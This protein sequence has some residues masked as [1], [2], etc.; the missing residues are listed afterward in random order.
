MRS[1]R[2]WRAAQ[3]AWEGSMRVWKSTVEPWRASLRL[4]GGNTG[5]QT[6]ESLGPHSSKNVLWFA[7]SRKVYCNS[8][9]ISDAIFHLEQINF[10][11]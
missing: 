6:R 4:Q 1:E 7:G 9:L 10:N 3:D 5:N 2:R 8:S 11:C